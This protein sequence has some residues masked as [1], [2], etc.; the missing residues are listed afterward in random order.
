MSSFTLGVFLS[1]S[2]QALKEVFRRFWN[3]V[4]VYVLHVCLTCSGNEF[5]ITHPVKIKNSVNKKNPPI[6]LSQLCPVNIVMKTN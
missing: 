1:G 2:S 5:K 6:P 3:I 4:S